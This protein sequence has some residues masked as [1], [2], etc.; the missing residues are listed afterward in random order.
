M[1]SLSKDLF[2]KLGKWIIV[3]VVVAAMGHLVIQKILIPV[4]NLVD[5]I[6][7]TWGK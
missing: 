4:L 5:S 3:A 7:P 6:L 1:L 2:G